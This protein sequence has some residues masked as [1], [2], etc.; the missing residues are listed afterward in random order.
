MSKQ[1]TTQ[2]VDYIPPASSRSK[3]RLSKQRQTLVLTSIIALTTL[4]ICYEVKQAHLVFPYVYPDDSAKYHLPPR[5]FTAWNPLFVLPG[6]PRIMLMGDS[7]TYGAADTEPKSFN[8]YHCSG[9]YRPFLQEIL[10]KE[11]LRAQ[12]VGSVVAGRDPGWQR[13]CEAHPGAMT[14]DFANH[15]REWDAWIHAD[16]YCIMIGT[17]DVTTCE[18]TEK[19]MRNV[20]T[21]IG[22][23]L[24]DNPKATLLVASVI[25]IGHKSQ[26]VL[27]RR[28]AYNIAL[29]QTVAGIDDPRVRFID[30]EK[31]SGITVNDIGVSGLHPTV[32]GYQKLAHGWSVAL[33]P[34]L[35]GKK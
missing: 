26:A 27:A 32:Q 2:S 22:D 6:T 31:L 17:N 1:E 24:H 8:I 12:F 29:Q 30:I 19:S 9:G 34:L 20:R 35:K 7:I 21:L 33:V 18:L 4:L 14:A 25:P 28:I 3:V 5:H 16:S 15:Y 10:T 23:I 13:A 11:G